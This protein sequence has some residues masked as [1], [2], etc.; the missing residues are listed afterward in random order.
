[1]RWALALQVYNFDVQYIKAT[2]SCEIKNDPSL[3]T[4]SGEA[5]ALP[6]PCRYLASHVQTTLLNKLGQPIGTCEARVRIERHPY[7]LYS[8]VIATQKPK[9]HSYALYPRVIA[10]DKPYRD[11]NALSIPVS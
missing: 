1:M 10:T 2:L 9:R 8:R 4:F 3:Q 11:I 7:A 5:E 6:F